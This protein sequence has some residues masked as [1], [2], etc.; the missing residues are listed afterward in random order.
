MNK[1][2][3]SNLLYEPGI[4]ENVAQQRQ[5]D[6]LNDETASSPVRYIIEEKQCVKTC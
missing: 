6:D 2:L 5:H 4:L 3:L 1:P